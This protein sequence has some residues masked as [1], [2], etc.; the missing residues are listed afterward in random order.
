LERLAE[1]YAR[2]DEVNTSY[3]SLW[4]DRENGRVYAEYGD[5]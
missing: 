3:W 2:V 5:W 1:R 4:V